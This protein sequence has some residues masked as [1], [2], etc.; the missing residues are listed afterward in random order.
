MTRESEYSLTA[1]SQATDNQIRELHAQGCGPQKISKLIQ[2]SRVATLRRMKAL[3]LVDEDFGSK[4]RGAQRKGFWTDEHIATLKRSL[5][6]GMSTTQIAE[7]F[8]CSS[9]AVQ[10]KMKSMGLVSKSKLGNRTKRLPYDR[11]V[12]K[13]EEKPKPHSNRV[14][15]DPPHVQAYKAARRGVVIPPHLEAEYYELL[16]QGVPIA[17]AKARLG[18]TPNQEGK[19]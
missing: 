10:N 16:K 5:S 9:T 11:L 8:G 13:R 7:V 2:R 3:G 19:A 15:N 1:F 17:E 4:P 12:E 18:V 6:K 14:I